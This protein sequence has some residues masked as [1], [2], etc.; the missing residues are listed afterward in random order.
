[1]RPN[2]HSG[3]PHEKEPPQPTAITEVTVSAWSLDPKRRRLYTQIAFVVAALLVAV[4]VLYFLRDFLGAFVLG[5]AISFLIQPAVTRLVS[6]GV[7][8]VVAISL[9]FVVIIVILA[10][11][12][13]LIV[14][15]GIKEVAQLQRQDSLI[16]MSSS[17]GGLNFQRMMKVAQPILRISHE[18]IECPNKHIGIGGSGASSLE[19][20]PI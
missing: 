20:F 14:P 18:E 13:L 4:V 17:N 1:M 9:L 10:G 8:R 5:A 15:L 6:A 12:V 2:P 16:G 7:P 19:V 3:S 11:V